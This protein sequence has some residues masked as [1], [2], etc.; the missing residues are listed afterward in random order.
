M[1]LE[2]QDQ[3][4]Q[5]AVTIHKDAKEIP[6]Q[7]KWSTK[8]KQARDCSMLIQLSLPSNLNNGLMGAA[9]L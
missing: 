8:H 6:K 9:L 7:A 2:R 5:H 4:L 1:Q 3:G